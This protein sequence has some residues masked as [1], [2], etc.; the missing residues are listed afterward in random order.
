MID[1]KAV[2]SYLH[3]YFRRSQAENSWNEYGRRKTEEVSSRQMGQHV[4][5]P[6]LRDGTV[7]M[8][9]GQEGEWRMMRLKDGQELNWSLTQI[10]LRSLE[11]I[12]WAMGIHGR[13]IYK[14]IILVL[15][16]WKERF[17]LYLCISQ[18]DKGETSESI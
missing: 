5:S 15:L 6:C 14:H 13:I 4:R 12:P 11:G 2:S 16:I 10:I 3:M 18:T 9:T 17:W 7:H 1:I 8:M